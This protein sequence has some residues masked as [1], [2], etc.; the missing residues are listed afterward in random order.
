MQ[1]KIQLK[2]KHKNDG[3]TYIH[4][5]TMASYWRSLQFMCEFIT[6]TQPTTTTW[7]IINRAIMLGHACM[8]VYFEICARPYEYAT[9][10]THSSS[11]SAAWRTLNF[12]AQH[13]SIRTDFRRLRLLMVAPPLPLPLPV[14]SLGNLAFRCSIQP[15]TC[16][17]CLAS[18][19]IIIII[20]EKENKIKNENEKSNAKSMELQWRHYF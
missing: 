8:C 16:R 19:I 3:V 9:A 13:K 10:V 5:S 14:P 15:T 11:Y 12:P 17:K 2:F 18:K 20:N 6:N 1:Q 4:T 7:L